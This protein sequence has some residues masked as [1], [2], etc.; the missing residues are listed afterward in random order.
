MFEKIVACLRLAVPYTG[1]II[2]TRESKEVREKVLDLGITQISGG[3]KTTVGGYSEEIGDVEGSNQFELADNRTLDEVVD[4]LL[5]MDYL[6]SF[7]TACY[8]EGRVGKDFMKIVKNYGIG[9]MC[10]P[11]AILTL[12]EYLTDYASEKTRKDGRALIEREIE[13]IENP[14]LRENTKKWL[15][16]IRDGKRDIHV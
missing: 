3:S 2:S 15:S 11:N 5:N 7:C 14:K 8:R 12:D 13:K 1:M 10:Q 9:N 4:W 16:E 6:P